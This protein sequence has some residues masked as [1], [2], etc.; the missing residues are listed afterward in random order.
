MLRVA[1][2]MGIG[3]LAREAAASQTFLAVNA[4]QASEGDASIRFNLNGGVYNNQVGSIWATVICGLS[5]AQ[6]VDQNDDIRVFFNDTNGNISSDPNVNM[7][8]DFSC[9]AFEV[10]DDW[11]TL[12][13]VGQKLGCSTPG[14]CAS[15]TPPV[16]GFTGENFIAFTDIQQGGAF[17]AMI[18]CNIP[19]KAGTGL[20][21]PVLKSLFLLK[22]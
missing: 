20:P 22:Q 14:G 6:A 12:L 10:A 8:N 19:A 7:R 11:S 13:F 21:N 17:S 2:V 9:G 16:N 1:L 4:C 5:Q 18:A 15:F 3:V